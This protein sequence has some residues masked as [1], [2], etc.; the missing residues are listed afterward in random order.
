M[1]FTLPLLEKELRS[2][3][4]RGVPAFIGGLGS[5]GLSFLRSL[6]R[7][8]IPVVGMDTWNRP[9]MLSRYGLPLV[10]PD[11][12]GHEAELLDLLLE[13]GESLEGRAVLIPTSDA[14][15]LFVSRQSGPLSRHFDFIVPD[16]E[17]VLRL[18]NKRLQ[19][20]FAREHHVPIPET[21]YP[22]DTSIEDIARETRYP[23]IIKP[24]FSHLWKKYADGLPGARWGKV[25]EVRSRE[26]L[27]AT[28]REM[29][30]SGLEF[31][32][33]DKIPG[34]DNELYDLLA[35]LNR[36]SEPLAAFTKHKLRCYPLEFGV[37]SLAIGQWE[38]ELA[39]SG[40]DFVVALKYKGV[41]S[42]E[43][44]RDSRDGVFKLMEVNPRSIL[45]TYLAVC[46]GVDIPY[47]AYLDAKGD[48][49]TAISSFHEGVKW[50]SFE[51]D[52]KAF[53]E[54]REAALLDFAEWA[55][56]WRGEKCFAVLAKDDPLPFCR[57][58]PEFLWGEWRG[59]RGPKRIR[60]VR[61]D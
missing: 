3:A 22:S 56:S 19:Y 46:S 43:F 48:P 31:L 15:I 7:R 5:N 25:A 2:R 14:F 11:P 47:L 61:Y 23:C 30:K 45:T 51:R 27:L 10:V 57:G 54:Y 42:P 16:H 39:K 59:R 58:F 55:Q 34:S 29:A 24:Y 4:D 33:Q 13:T 38:P 12:A 17:T 53:L 26:E 32:V 41:V 35:Y 28:Y 36:N 6:G 40:L 9:E 18:A 20:D 52:V 49:V 21:F 1:A 8:G 37:S 50:I 60:S 44:K